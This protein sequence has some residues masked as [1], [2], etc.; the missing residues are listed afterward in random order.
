MNQRMKIKAETN[1][2]ENKPLLQAINKARSLYFEKTKKVY[3]SLAVMI[4]N[5][6]WEAQK[7]NIRNKK[8]SIIINALEN[9]KVIKG[10][11]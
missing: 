6:R 4:N 8:G 3:K 5:K 9:N 11:D 10:Y 1:E 7:S 2:I